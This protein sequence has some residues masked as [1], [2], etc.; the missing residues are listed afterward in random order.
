MEFVGLLLVYSHPAV[1][2]DATT[3]QQPETTTIKT[4]E[5]RDERRTCPI[6]QRIIAANAVDAM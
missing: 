3:Q 4:E 6:R 1:T 5:T 2:T